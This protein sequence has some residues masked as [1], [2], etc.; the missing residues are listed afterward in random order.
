[1]EQDYMAE[2]VSENL[3]GVEYT[4]RPLIYQ[5]QED[6]NNELADVAAKGSVMLQA[7]AIAADEIRELALETV[8]PYAQKQQTETQENG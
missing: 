7:I 8:I 4:L 3:K 1:M 2:T 5:V 6:Q